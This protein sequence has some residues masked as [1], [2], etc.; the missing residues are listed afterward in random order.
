M[1]TL[2]AM[3][4]IVLTAKGTPVLYAVTVAALPQCGS[5]MFVATAARKG[6]EG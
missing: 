5:P 1:A 2:G 4:A 6:S 3:A